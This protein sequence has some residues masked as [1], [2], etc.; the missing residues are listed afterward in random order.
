MLG[1]LVMGASGVI[2]PVE[3]TD[4]PKRDVVVVAQGRGG[5]DVEQVLRGVKATSTWGDVAQLFARSRNIPADSVELVNSKQDTAAEVP[6]D[7]RI[8]QQAVF[9]TR[10][11]PCFA[12]AF[13][14]HARPKKTDPQPPAPKVAS[15]A[16]PPAAARPSGLAALKARLPGAA[17]LTPG[18]PPL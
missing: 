7:A 2:L 8:G 14:V 4:A 9:V 6:L 17:S 13:V 10:R 5:Q 16:A 18:P 3:E 15:P 1:E 12:T 11:K